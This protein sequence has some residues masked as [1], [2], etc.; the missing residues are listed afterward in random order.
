MDYQI[1]VLVGSLRK[2]SFNLQ[3]ARALEKLMPAHFK[4]TYADLDLPIYN[5]DLDDAMPPSVLALKDLVRSS[6]ALLF[7]TPEHNRSIPAALKNAIDWASRPYGQGVWKGK[8]CGVVGITPGTMGTSMAQQ[9][10]RNILSAQGVAAMPLPEVFLQ[11]KDG[12]F[13][14]DHTIANES[15]RT[16]LQ[17]WVDRYV[18]WVEK[19]AV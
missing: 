9:H 19:L 16:F 17:G 2:A 10:L 3:L 15:T 4:L 8:P 7:V 12:L 6:H 1:A 11:M 18:A 5:Q 14:A 13:Q